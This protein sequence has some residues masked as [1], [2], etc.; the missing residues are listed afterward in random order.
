MANEKLAEGIRKFAEDLVKL[1]DNIK[2]LVSVSPVPE[3]K[4]SN[5]D[6]VPSQPLNDEEKI[7]TI[8]EKV[9]EQPNATN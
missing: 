6:P 5:V 4:E 9:S 2:K 1:E 3:I 7:T 8:E